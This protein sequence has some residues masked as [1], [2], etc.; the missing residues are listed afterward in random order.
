VYSFACLVVNVILWKNIFA[1][2]TARIPTV[3]LGAKDDSAFQ[4]QFWVA[5]SG[6]KRRPGASIP[7]LREDAPDL[8]T[9]VV[10]F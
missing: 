1:Q 10:G 3:S 9:H 5:G 6:P 8:G 2:E 7:G 4:N